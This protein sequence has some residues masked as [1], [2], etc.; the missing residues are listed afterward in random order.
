MIN[1]LSPEYKQ[2]LLKEKQFKIVVILIIVTISFLISLALVLFSVEIYTASQLDAEKNFLEYSQ[3]EMELF[4]IEELENKIILTNEEISKLDTFYAQQSSAIE[5]LEKISQVVPQGI[6]F[7][8]IALNTASEEGYKFVLAINGFS[9][10]RQSL[11]DL[12]KNLENNRDFFKTFNFPSS[13]WTKSED[14][15]FSLILKI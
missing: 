9:P 10:D 14:I 1:L 8:N 6:Y 2:E 12:E 4:K 3:R 15:E 5:I 11:L 7:R 13:I